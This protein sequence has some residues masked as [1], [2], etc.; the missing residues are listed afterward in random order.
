MLK[1]NLYDKM[2]TTAILFIC[3]V[4]CLAL[5]FGQIELKNANV[6]IIG[7]DNILSVSENV[8]LKFPNPMRGQS[9]TN[10]WGEEIT[11]E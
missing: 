2:K 8:Q 3:Q 6:L 10:Y 7:Y 4:F 5:G 11:V 9:R 1:Q